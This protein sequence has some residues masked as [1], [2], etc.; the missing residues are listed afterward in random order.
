MVMDD[1][2]G[3]ESILTELDGLVYRNVSDY[4]AKYFP[5]IDRAALHKLAKSTAKSSARTWTLPPTSSSSDTLHEWI[6]GFLSQQTAKTSRR[7]DSRSFPVI[8]SSSSSNKEACAN[9]CLVSEVDTRINRV[10]PGSDIL[11]LGLSEHGHAK[12]PNDTNILRFCKTARDLLIGRSER[13]FLHAFHIFNSTMEM[14]TFDKAGAV[15]SDAFDIEEKPEYFM[16]VMTCYIRMNEADAGLNMILKKDAHAMFI[17]QHD[18]RILHIDDDAFVKPDCL[19]GPGTTCFKARDADAKVQK[20]VVKFA[21]SEPDHGGGGERNLLAFANEQN[22]LGILKLE[23]H[24]ALGD[25]AQ[26]RQGLQFDTSYHFRLPRP[27]CQG[28]NE[29]SPESRYETPE[30][31]RAHN[32]V[33]KYDNLIFECIVTSPLGQSIDTFTTISVLMTVF[34]DSIK[35][36]RSLYF[37]AKILHRDISRQNIIIVPNDADP[38]SPTGMLID[39]DLALDLANP[40]SEEGLVGS[41]EFMAIGLLGGDNHTY[42]H[43]LESVFYT[44]LWI[45]ICHNGTTSEHIPESSC[46]HN[47]CGTDFLA[48][49]H[50]KRNDMQPTEFPKLLHEFTEPFREYIPLAITL[51]KLLFPVRNDK[52]FI[53]TDFDG[54]ST[55]RLYAGMMAVG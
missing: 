4:A 6:S 31:S 21:W 24:H 44:F 54:D 13:R 38:E 47:W 23:G 2:S 34:R 3:L 29:M 8:G 22:V 40:P 52:I 19:V 36:L 17:E 18:G 26:F 43:D 42:R 11:V 33:L 55:E 27:R 14:W 9:L 20:L 25:I 30:S 5:N 7:F 12:L 50:S 51:H 37:D 35:A 16:A 46:L 32:E 10:C 28:D 39:L 45:A 15:S 1:F 49:F 41:E 53:G 48:S